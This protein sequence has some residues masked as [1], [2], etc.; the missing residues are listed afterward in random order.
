MTKQELKDDLLHLAL[1]ADLQTHVFALIDAADDVDQVLLD[2]I[3]DILALDADLED[4]LADVSYQEAKKYKEFAEHVKTVSE[5]S[6]NAR[7]K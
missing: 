5:G 7:Q 2:T 6:G 1:D 4:Q 3:A